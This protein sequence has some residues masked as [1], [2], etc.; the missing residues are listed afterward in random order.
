MNEKVMG[1]LW[2]SVVAIV[3]FFVVKRTRK[4]RGKKLDLDAR[5]IGESRRCARENAGLILS[6]AVDPARLGGPVKKKKK[7][8][9]RDA[10]QA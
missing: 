10:G 7:K 3:Q 1:S 6:R 5:S 4:R 2:W 8:Y 9:V